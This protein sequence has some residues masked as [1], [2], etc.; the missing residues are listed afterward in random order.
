MSEA[1]IATSMLDVQ[2]SQVMGPG[3]VFCWPGGAWLEG[4]TAQAS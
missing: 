2:R 1:D 4:K 3:A